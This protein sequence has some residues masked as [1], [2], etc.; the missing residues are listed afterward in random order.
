MWNGESFLRSY[1]LGEGKLNAYLD[2]YAFMVQGLTELYEVTFNSR[3]LN[4]AVD[5]SHQMIELFQ[6]DHNGGFFFTSKDHEKLIVRKKMSQDGA[7]PSGNSVAVLSLLRLSRI[8]GKVDFK[9]AAEKTIETFSHILDSTPSALHMMLVGLDFYL[10]TPMEI[11]LSGNLESGDTKEMLNVIHSV[12]LPNK[13][14]AFNSNDDS[15]ALSLPILKDKNP[16]DN[17]ATVFL[18]EN[19][20]CKL[21]MTDPEVVRTSL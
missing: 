9:R 3:W 19:Y 21:P 7:I 15:E 13:V 4:A 12:Y 14:V 18:C 8:S 2:D 1:R 17:K 20:A 5:I 11:V 10:D 6:D 16:V